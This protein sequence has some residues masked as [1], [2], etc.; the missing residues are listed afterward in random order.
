MVMIFS[1]LPCLLFYL[2]PFNTIT[3]IQVTSSNTRI[4]PDL[5]V[6]FDIASCYQ[7]MLFNMQNIFTLDFEGAFFIFGSIRLSCLAKLALHVIIE[8]FDRSSLVTVNKFWITRYLFF[9]VYFVFN[10]NTRNCNW[11]FRFYFCVTVTSWNVLEL[12]II[13]L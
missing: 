8:K 3:L 4:W 10:F 13:L 2:C 5:K 11:L 6:Y 7:V 9:K 1:I 12:P